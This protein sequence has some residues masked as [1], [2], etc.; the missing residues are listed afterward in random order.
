MQR[1]ESVIPARFQNGFIV[2]VG[3]PATPADVQ[4]IE[5]SG[6][7]VLETNIRGW[8]EYNAV[9]SVGYGPESATYLAVLSNEAIMRFD[10]VLPNRIRR[11]LSEAARL[12]SSSQSEVVSEALVE[13][14]TGGNGSGH[15]RLSQA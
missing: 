8:G 14:L 5:Q 10:L 1:L 11:M 3:S 12:E 13:Y 9:I 4:W 6:Y 7:D 15:G 2:S